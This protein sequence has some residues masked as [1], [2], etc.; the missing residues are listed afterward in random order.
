MEV[1][2]AKFETAKSIPYNVNVVDIKLPRRATQNSAGYDLVTPIDVKVPAYGRVLVPL[3]ITCKMDPTEY[4]Q[5]VPR[6]GLANKKGITV[7]NTPGTIDADYYPNCIGVIL[8][9]STDKDVFLDK[10]ERIA[11]AILQTYGRMEDDNP[12]EKQREGGFG[13]T[14]RS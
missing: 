4:L 12:V 13:S 11:Q 1:F 2:M 5:I 8:Y 14:G 7:L 9:N 10:G 3:G 6:S